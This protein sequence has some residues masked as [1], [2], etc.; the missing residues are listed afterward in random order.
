[1]EILE[2]K[3]GDCLLVR[4]NPADCDYQLIRETFQSFITGMGFQNVHYLILPNCAQVD[5]LRPGDQTRR[6]I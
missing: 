1:M 5:V 4:F 2:I 3:D 6:F